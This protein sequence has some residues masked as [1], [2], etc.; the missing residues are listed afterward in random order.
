MGMLSRLFRFFFVTKTFISWAKTCA[1]CGYLLSLPLVFYG[2]YQGLQVPADVTQGE[3]FRIIYLHVPLAAFSLAVY[4]IMALFIILERLLHLKMADVYAISC[5]FVGALIT[6][7][8]LV[9]GSIWAKPTWGAWWIWDARITCE[10]LLLLLYVA[11]L[12]A[13]LQIKPRI[14]ATEISS[15][16]A[17]IGL[18]DLP[19]IHYSV[20]W[21]YTLHQGP[22]VLQFAAPKMPWVMLYPLIICMSG[23]ALLIAAL[24]VHTAFVFIQF[25]L[26][27]R[28]PA[29]TVVCTAD[30]PV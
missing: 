9:T 5:A 25:S 20:Q 2:F 15:W 8:A 28:Q 3:V 16:I 24:I 4:L 30:N 27:S 10:V 14:I 7:L 13:R 21:W 11:Y 22:T 19:L 26:L 17:I 6:V 23:F 29:S 12:I 18:I 1:L